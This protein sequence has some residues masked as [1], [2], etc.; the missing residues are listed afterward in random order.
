M[1]VKKIKYILPV[2]F[3]AILLS[4]LPACQNNTEEE[5]ST[6]GLKIISTVFPGYDFARQIA[7]NL[8][9]VTLLL[10]PGTESH[11]YEPTPGD[12]IQIQE[13]DLFLYVGGESDAWVEE[14]LAS[15]TKKP[16]VF[17]LMDCVP[18]AEEEA[19]GGESHDH[20]EEYDEHVWTSPKNAI[21]IA[22]ELGDAIAALCEEEKETVQAGTEAY[23]AELDQL[24]RDFTEFSESLTEKTLIF[25]DRFPFLYFAKAY[26][27]E[28]YAAFPG[29]S[30][31]TEPS[32]ATMSF[33]IDK[34]KE[35]N[36]STVFYI[37]F[38]NHLVA[39]S[40]AEA[41][42]AKTALLHS[43]HNLTKDEMDAGQTY[44]S[45]MERNLNTL[46]EALQ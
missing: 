20:G 30:A 14:I 1:R 8:A 9:D 37:E 6:D 17:K 44:I 22:R 27:F 39:D 16:A 46:R 41:T 24:D 10:P 28:H 4:M 3:C 43:C 40:L 12:I 19:E 21:L 31:E 33:L 25:G 18:L 11:S 23:V 35:E 26:G 45:L 7:G 15:L 36:V 5:T 13:C 34:I 32:A 42:G 2:F 38:S 29:C